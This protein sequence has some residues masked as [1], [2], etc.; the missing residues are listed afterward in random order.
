MVRE[1]RHRRLMI[2]SPLPP[3]PRSMSESVLRLATDIGGT[4]TD[5]ASFDRSNG[6][7]RFGKTLTTPRSLVEGIEIGIDKAQARLADA[8]LFLHG[9]TVAINAMLERTGAP[10]ALITTHGFRDVYEIGRVNRPDAYNLFFSKHKP[11]VPRHH[12][13]EVAERLSA[14]GEILT[15][16]DENAVRQLASHLRSEKIEAIAILFLHCYRNPEHE[17]R[18]KAILQEE[19]PNHFISASTSCRRSIASSSGVRLLSPTLMSGRGCGVI[20]KK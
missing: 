12:R 16:L 11:L 17:R 10:T 13:Y 4:F 18:A 8:S 9:T 3:A 1:R 6:Q 19:L 14:S 7:L 20:L 15:S 5:V 2:L